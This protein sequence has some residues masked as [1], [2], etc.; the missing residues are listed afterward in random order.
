MNLVSIRTEPLASPRPR[1]RVV[2][3]KWAHTYFPA[4]YKKWRAFIAS[5]LATKFKKT[6]RPSLL[7][8]DFGISKPKTTKFDTPAGDIDNYA[9]SLMDAITDSKVLED[10]RQV[11]LLIAKKCWSDL[12]YVKV[13]LKPLTDSELDL[14]WSKLV[15]VS[16]EE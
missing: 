6:G 7:I 14:L 12:P 9:K 2:A 16:S 8:C 3:G 11:V 5:R 10:D 13:A 4:I 15:R 1:F